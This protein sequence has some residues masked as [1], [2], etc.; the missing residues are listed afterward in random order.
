MTIIGLLTAA[1]IGCQEKLTKEITQK[2][3]ESPTLEIAEYLVFTDCKSQM[4]F[5]RYFGPATIIIYVCILMIYLS[6][7]N[8]KLIL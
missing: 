4:K 2:E 1:Q 5:T 7:N 3:T 8:K 6:K